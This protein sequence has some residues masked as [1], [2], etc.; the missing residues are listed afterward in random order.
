MHLFWHQRDLRIP[1]N[2]GLALAAKKEPTLPVYVVDTDLLKQ[3]GKRQRAFLLNGVRALKQRYRRLGTDLLVRVGSP[4]ETLESL[5]SEYDAERVYYNRHYRPA[6]RNRQRAVDEALPTKSVTDLVLV[7]P[8]RLAPRYPNHSQFYDDWQDQHKVTPFDVPDEERFVSL[9]DD[10][11]PPSVSADIDLPTAGYRAARDRYDQFLTAG[12]E[13]YNDTRDDM[14]RAVEQPVGAVSRLSPYIAGGMLGIREIWADASERYE[15]ARGSAQRNIGKFRYE[16]SW[17]E[18]NYHLLYYNPTLLVENYKSFPNDIEWREDDDHLDAWK[19]GETGYPFVD[20][21]MRQLNEEG[22]IHNRPRQVVASFLTKHLL[23][24]WRT[25]AKYFKRQL[26]DH[27]PANNYGNWQWIAS[28]GTDSVDVRIFD[29][30]SQ[31]SKY[32]DGATYVTEYVSEL[33]DVPAD[34]IIDWPTL[35]RG[36]RE[37]LA[38]EYPHPI[39]DRNEGYERAQRTFERALGKR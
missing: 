23:V 9:S 20:A 30:V 36:E 32:D 35:S 22:Y 24:D 37:R 6:R 18:Q 26:I 21:G 31:L 25:G 11:G 17:R 5:C 1:D 29:P 10:T 34:K 14:Q 28:T 19:R 15:G 33:R 27:D 16:L 13:S 7:D 8:E 3:I 39:V 12:I 4:A 38:P 2:R